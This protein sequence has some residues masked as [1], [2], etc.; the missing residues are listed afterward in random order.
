MSEERAITLEFLAAQSQR[1]LTELRI[2]RDDVDVLAATMGRIDNNYDRLENRMDM[3]IAEMR[4]VRQ[5]LRAMHAQH[6]HTARRVRALE[7]REP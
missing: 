6:D 2:I 1:V 3:L 4:E 7:E 5:E